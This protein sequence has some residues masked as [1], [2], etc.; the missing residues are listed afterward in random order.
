MKKRTRKERR[1]DFKKA[2]LDGL[3]KLGL[4]DKKETI[5]EPK[6]EAKET[7]KKTKKEEK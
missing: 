4:L 1:E 3:K 7:K 5:E 2:Y 6:E